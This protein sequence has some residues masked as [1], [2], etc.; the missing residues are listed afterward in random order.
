MPLDPAFIGNAVTFPQL[1]RNK[2]FRSDNPEDLE[3][4]GEWKLKTFS[5]DPDGE[6]ITSYVW[7]EDVQAVIPMEEDELRELLK[8]SVELH[9]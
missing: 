4:G 9:P 1:L 6:Q 2:R 7:F 8:G 3:A 5:A